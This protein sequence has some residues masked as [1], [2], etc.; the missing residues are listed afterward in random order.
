MLPVKI[1]VQ[2]CRVARQEMLLTEE[3]VERMMD[4]IDGVP[5]SRLEALR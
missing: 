2:A 4:A 3:Y 5:E 1:N